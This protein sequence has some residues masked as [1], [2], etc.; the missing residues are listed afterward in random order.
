MLDRDAVRLFVRNLTNT[1]NQKLRELASRRC[2]AERISFK[3]ESISPC[4]NRFTYN[5]LR[6]GMITGRVVIAQK[7]NGKLGIVNSWHV[8]PQEAKHNAKR[9]WARYKPCTNS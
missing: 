2:P 8:T 1:T 6:G 7:A 3:L 4:G 9:R 5:E